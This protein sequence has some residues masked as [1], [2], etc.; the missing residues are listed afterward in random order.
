MK[1]IYCSLYFKFLSILLP[2]SMITM[3][4]LEISGRELDNCYNVGSNQTNIM[5]IF[6][7]VYFWK[8]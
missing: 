3:V 6:I 1:E 4:L 8:I 5:I 2:H 7:C